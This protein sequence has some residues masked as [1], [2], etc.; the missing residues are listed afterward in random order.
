MKNF[1]V[2]YEDVAC[3][4]CGSTS[5]EIIYKNCKDLLHKFPGKFNIVRCKNCGLV[6]LTPRPKKEFISLYY[7]ENYISYQTCLL[8]EDYHKASFK[9]KLHHRVTMF[10]DNRRISLIDRHFKINREDLVLDFGCGKA[11]TLYNL[12]RKYKCKVVGIDF[13]LESGT[14]VVNNLKIPFILANPEQQILKPE[15][16]QLITMWHYLEHSY[17]P[18][19]V[20]Q[21]AYRYL[22]RGGGL[23]IEVPNFDS[24]ERKIFRKHWFSL[25]VPR[26]L[27]YFTPRTISQYLEK[28]NFKVMEIH[29]RFTGLLLSSVLFSLR[30]NPFKYFI[31]PVALFINI[32]ISP[33]E[34][35]LT[36]LKTSGVI[37]VY[38]IKK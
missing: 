34:L 15:S 1:N 26:H 12:K 17:N 33:I 14:Y 29:Y 5:Y 6:Y 38:A 10:E 30:I 8:K 23:L 24:I 19:L 36:R 31:N 25:D 13:S 3:N 16:C 28:Y 18:D 4:F 21:N 2:E 7:P 37:T 35:I 32:F 20:I 11:T 9:E 27:Y 22:K